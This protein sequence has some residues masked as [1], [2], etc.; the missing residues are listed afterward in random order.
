MY[1][2]IRT[3]VVRHA[4]TAARCHKSGKT[5][6]CLGEGQGRQVLDLEQGGM[7]ARFV[8]QVYET[9][10][11]L[12][13]F[14]WEFAAPCARD[15]ATRM[16]Q[17]GRLIDS[18]E[19]E[20]GDVLQIG[21]GYPGHVAVYVGEVN[22]VESLVENTSD[23]SRGVPRVA[24]TKLTPWK[25]VAGRVT[26]VFRLLELETQAVRISMADGRQMAVGELRGGLVWAP[27]RALCEGLGHRVEAKR[28]EG[29]VMW[30]EVG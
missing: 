15:M 25:S 30:V 23:Q 13:P 27:V 10:L 1:E 14:T 22:G 11:E 6:L 16:R 19:R 12:A 4:L 17:A 9:A 2:G 5:S 21:S 8:R 29:G 20:P 18:A 26:G 3:R 28:D 24:G 7:C